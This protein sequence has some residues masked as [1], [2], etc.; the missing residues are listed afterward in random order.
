MKLKNICKQYNV[1]AST[2]ATVVFNHA[3]LQITPEMK[4]IQVQN[5]DL[6]MRQHYGNMKFG[7]WKCV[8]K[9]DAALEAELEASIERVA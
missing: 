5:G 3:T 8:T 9:V 4:Q 6:Y 2:I 1:K 7:A